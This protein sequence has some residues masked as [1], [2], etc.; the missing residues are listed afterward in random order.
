MKTNVYLPLAAIMV[1]AVAAPLSLHCSSSATSSEEFGNS[2]Q[3][4]T[5]A[6]VMEPCLD[7]NGGLLGLMPADPSLTPE[8]R[9]G[10][11]TWV[12][13]TGGTENLFRRVT[14]KTKGAAD[15]LMLVD[16]RYRDQRWKTL[17][18]LNDPGCKPATR[19]DQYGLWL[20]DCQDPRSAGMIGFRKIPNPQ[21]DAAK[22]SLDAYKKDATIEP[23][24]L[25][26][27]ACGSCHVALNPTK[28]PAD[29][30]HPG[31]DNFLFA[32]GNQYLDE[33][34]YFITPFKEDDFRWHVLRTQER[35]TSDTSRQ[36]T[37]HINN[38]NSI[39]AI[40]NL[41]D[42]PT[43]LEVMNDGS[44]QAVHHIL[45]DG[46]DSIGVAGASLR[47][48]V[49]EGMCVD[50]WLKHH[51]L[52]DGNTEQT[53]IRR[54]DLYRTCKDYSDTAA[55][56]DDM[57]AFLKSQGPVRLVDAPGGDQLITK[58]ESVL[59]QGKLAFAHAC[60]SCH[61]SKQPPADVIDAA[62]R[63]AWFEQS[64]L[65]PT[66]LDHNFLSDDR[67]YPITELK[68]NAAR[69]L[70]TNPT[71]GHIW[72]DYS[73]KTFKELPSPGT[74]SLLN[75]YDP[76]HPI[77]FKVPSG[78]VGYYRTPS[79]AAIWAT[80]PLLHNNALG[81]FNGDPSVA[82]RIDAFNDAITKLLWPAQRPGTI[83][84][85]TVDSQLAL[86]IGTIRVPAGT[87]VNILA[88]VDPRPLTTKIGMEML[89]LLGAVNVTPNDPL[90]ATAILKYLN[91][92]PDLVEDEG[93]YYG[94]DLSDGDKRA[95]IEFLK[96]L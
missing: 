23:P 77:S 3:A 1:A 9:R 15:A 7:D 31:W 89:G 10:R 38:P 68:T 29:P 76:A 5:A 32:F 48:F 26:G 63:N 73:S 20:D 92:C 55:R 72:E 47:V 4:M 19:P 43:A 61:S 87:P 24:Y 2:D 50:E 35:G 34:S 58:D 27:T 70:G 28:P 52:L 46:S 65:S 69:A 16:S 78:G 42:R 51:D 82:G 64:V 39:N 84:R 88:N 66:F 44:V 81:K 90:M 21:F 36:A 17:G 18:S 13:H 25:V 80:A 85:T 60:A 74:L 57:A 54:A 62:A 22:W 53:P 86:P 6:P 45:K 59:T 8:Q 14:I 33:A 91:Q 75:P 79:I 96:T 67:R 94:T 40:I 56:M 11:C 83:K 37:D 71:K 49:N 30:A 41:A 93:H 95:L 12:L